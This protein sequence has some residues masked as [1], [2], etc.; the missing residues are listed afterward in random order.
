MESPGEAKSFT[1]NG[2][3]S[4]IVKKLAPYW[5]DPASAAT[6]DGKK[7]S[8]MLLS[9]VSCVRVLPPD[10]EPVLPYLDQRLS[11]AFGVLCASE[12]ELCR[13]YPDVGGASVRAALE[14]NLC[15]TSASWRVTTM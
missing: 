1:V 5:A 13:R 11:P 3:L 8:A 9:L 4:S 6:P 12:P 2:T 14:G 15:W 7:V 10:N